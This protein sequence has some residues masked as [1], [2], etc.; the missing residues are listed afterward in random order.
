[1]NELIIP[2]LGLVP[3]DDVPFEIKK[4]IR[5]V[6]NAMNAG[7]TKTVGVLEELMVAGWRINLNFTM[8]PA[9]CEVGMLTRYSNDLNGFHQH[10]ELYMKIG[11]A[12]KP[13]YDELVNKHGTEEQK[14]KIK[15]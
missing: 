4:V 8:L 5:K 3:A 10:K 9:R 11:R 15:A 7:K 12:Y 1:M 6:Q 13:A 14:Q 2:G